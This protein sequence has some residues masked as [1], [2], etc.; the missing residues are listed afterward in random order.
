MAVP[1]LADT[2]AD[3]DGDDGDDLELEAEVEVCS[4]LQRRH[5]VCPFSPFARSRGAAAV[6]CSGW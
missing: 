3:E 2:R 1:C 6:A 5:L 4:P